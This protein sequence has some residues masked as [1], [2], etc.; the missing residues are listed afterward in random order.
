[1]KDRFSHDSAGYANFRPHYP[2]NVFKELFGL[3]VSFDAALDV[4][5]GNGQVAR[6]LARKFSQVKA[7]DISKQQIKNAYQA[8]NL[9][10]SIQPAE[11]SSFAD[12]SFDL[13]TVGQAVHWFDFNSFYAEVRRLLKP[14]GLLA[15]LGY[16]LIQ[17]EPSV[18]L[19]IGHFY[20]DILGNYWDPER[21]WID[22]NYQ[23][24]PFPFKEVD[25]SIH[26]IAYSWNL[27]QLTGYLQTWSAVKNYKNQTGLDIMP[28]V[29][30]ELK[31][32]FGERKEVK[33][34][35]PILARIGKV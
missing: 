26:T 33:V 18:E 7:T 9:E 24:I 3:C 17:S 5:T 28:Q 2:E 14:N 34:S 31:K 27:E 16:G 32:A 21:K 19:I 35:F 12:H 6:H 29:T 15:I 23:T 8:S 13:I 10:Y 1:M 25:F 20:S 30:E 4:A 22:E 11:E